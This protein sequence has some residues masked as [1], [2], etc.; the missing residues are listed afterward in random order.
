MSDF[1]FDRS[2]SEA[3]LAAA[4]WELNTF[5]HSNPFDSH[6]IYVC[7]FR[8]EHTQLFSFSRTDFYELKVPLSASELSGAVCE[9]M[10]K[11][12]DGTLTDEESKI[13]SPALA[14]YIKATQTF[15][16]WQSQSDAH[17]RLHA[18]L[19]IYPGNTVRPFAGQSSG[20]VLQPEAVLSM[21]GG[22]RDMDLARHPEWFKPA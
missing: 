4:G 16:Q 2:V 21:A 15:R 5:N 22:V 18:I 9:L 14:A 20:T 17:S 10:Q 7:D 3:H 19:N 11:L 8:N 13:L 12:S 6:F 1:D